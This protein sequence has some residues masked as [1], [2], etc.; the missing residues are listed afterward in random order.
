MC[1]CGSNFCPHR[2]FSFAMPVTYPLYPPFPTH[3]VN[4]ISQYYISP[5]PSSVDQTKKKNEQKKRRRSGTETLS[6]NTVIHSCPETTFCSSQCATSQNTAIPPFTV[7]N[8]SQNS[9]LH[10]CCPTPRVPNTVYSEGASVELQSD[11]HDAIDSPILN[12]CSRMETSPSSIGSP[13]LSLPDI[14]LDPP[15]LLPNNQPAE[16]SSTLIPQLDII[17][18]FHSLPLEVQIKDGKPFINLTSILQASDIK[19]KAGK[20]KLKDSNLT[21]LYESYLIPDPTTTKLVHYVS[22]FWFISFL[23]T[24]HKYKDRVQFMKLLAADVTDTLMKKQLP[25]ISEPSQS[26]QTNHPPTTSLNVDSFSEALNKRKSFDKMT[27]TYRNKYI[28][29][30]FEN[31]KKLFKSIGEEFEGCFSVYYDSRPKEFESLLQSHVKKED[32]NVNVSRIATLKKVLDKSI[33][34]VTRCCKYSML[35]FKDFFNISDET[36][37]R[38]RKF[39]GLCILLPCCNTINTCRGSVNNEIQSRYSVKFQEGTSIWC[40]LKN[41]VEDVLKINQDKDLS[42]LIA[43]VTIDKGARTFTVGSLSLLNIGLAPQSRHSQLVFYLSEEGENDTVL[44]DILKKIA[45]EKDN[46]YKYKDKECKM[47]FFL[48]NDLKALGLMTDLYDD[49]QFC[50][51]CDCKSKFRH[52]FEKCT[53]L[54]LKFSEDIDITVMICSLHLKMRVVGNL[55][56]QFLK[57]REHDVWDEV[58]DKIREYKHCSQFNWRNEKFEDEKD[59][60]DQRYPKL[61]YMNGD[62]CDMILNNFKE[63][64]GKHMT[65]VEILAWE[66]VSILIYNYIEGPTS[67]KGNAAVKKNLEEYCT[68]LKHCMTSEYPSSKFAHY[69]HIVVMHLPDLIFNYGNLSQFA[70]EGSENIHA[71]HILGLERATAALPEQYKSPMEQLF[72]QGCRKFFLAAQHKFPWLG[73]LAETDE[74]HAKKK[75]LEKNLLHTLALFQK[76][77]SLNENENTS[78]MLQALKTLTAATSHVLNIEEQNNHQNTEMLTNN[79]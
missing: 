2:G 28:T 51:F 7:I 68:L 58:A 25:N 71:G 67:N 34:T 55:M 42:E 43:K 77:E 74:Y 50:P 48:V 49:D 41:M 13:F 8:I 3:S 56:S 63:I 44:N 5:F 73:K 64:F 39:T 23:F 65:P 19:R 57:K 38:F 1:K 59:D 20:F 79:Y 76:A 35:Y 69:I 36:Y 32:E 40:K 62:Q 16:T 21:K 17:P 24:S 75:K 46:M 10:N 31:I 53:L 52:K 45:A 12:D 6:Q 70:N 33:E 60:F 9:E 27:T 15:S 29:K 11:I 22:V 26:S 18:S 47:K 61:P 4:D 37:E 54:N 14:G 78:V 72:F 66:I 30:I